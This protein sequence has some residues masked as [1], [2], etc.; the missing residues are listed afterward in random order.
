MDSS[1]I[2]L[3]LWGTRQETVTIIGVRAHVLSRTPP[4]VGSEVV[5]PSSGGSSAQQ[6][7]INLDHGEPKAVEPLDE[8]IGGPSYFKAHTVTLEK[9]EPID[10]TIA[11]ITLRDTV[12][13]RLEV[14]TESGNKRETVVVPGDFITTPS[15]PKGS[16]GQRWMWRWDLRPPHLERVGPGEE[17]HYPPSWAAGAG[18]T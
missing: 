12:R 17:I 1:P 15:Q 7:A 2:R 6:V 16:Y 14:D 13:W 3:H 8:L 10:F 4:I 9:G 18:G 5:C 11:A